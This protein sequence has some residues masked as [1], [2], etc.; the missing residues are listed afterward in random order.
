MISPSPSAPALMSASSCC[1]IFWPP[2]GARSR[3]LMAVNITIRSL[4]RLALIASSACF[5]RSP[6][7]PLAFTITCRLSGSIARPTV[8]TT[9][10]PVSAGGWPWMSTTGNFARGHRM[11]RHDE[12]RARLV[13]PDGRLRQVGLASLGRTRPDL[14][15][16]L[17]LLRQRRPIESS[18]HGGREAP[19]R[20][21]GSC[22][23]ASQSRKT[24]Q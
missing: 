4:Y 13:F 8:F 1:A 21:G 5:S 17:R 14:A 6:D 12:R 19:E 24:S 22:R 23:N 7:V 18:E 3:T 10:G 11:L 15:G 20:E 9:S 16:G 2:P